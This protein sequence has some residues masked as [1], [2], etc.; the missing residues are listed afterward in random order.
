MKED[1][2]DFIKNQ[3]MDHTGRT[4]GLFLG[5]IVAILMLTIGFWATVFISICVG[6]GMYVGGSYD[7]DDTEKFREAF[8]KFIYKI[9]RFLPPYRRF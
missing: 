4:L 9:Q 3:I 1:L 5:L 8:Y 7:R 2:L 6:I